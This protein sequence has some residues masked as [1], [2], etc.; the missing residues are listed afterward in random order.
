[1]ILTCTTIRT[2]GI[3]HFNNFLKFKILLKKYFFRDLIQTF[4]QTLNVTYYSNDE[5]QVVLNKSF[6]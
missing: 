6:N 4:K 1:M 2:Q 3:Y 5:I